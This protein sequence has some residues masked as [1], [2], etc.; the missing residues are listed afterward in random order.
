M[1]VRPERTIL[2]LTFSEDTPLS[3]VKVKIG[4]CNIR[5]MNSM[6]DQD[7]GTTGKQVVEA[8]RYVEGLFFKY[9]IEWNLDDEDGNPLPK[10]QE[11]METLEPSI[12][13]QLIM[14]WQTAMMAVPT[15]SK[16]QS[17]N[18]GISEELSLGLAKSSESLES[19]PSQSS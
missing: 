2:N 11:G 17:Q 7:A 14:S 16:K 12:L 5:E 1:G 18:G 8:N 15:K 3:E 19:W 6:L 13:T 9:L 10:T 4:C